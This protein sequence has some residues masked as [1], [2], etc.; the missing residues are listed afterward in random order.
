LRVTGKGLRHRPPDSK[1]GAA[2]MVCG[3]SIFESTPA[4]GYVPVADCVPGLGGNPS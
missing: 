3:A 2:E 4:V 1:I